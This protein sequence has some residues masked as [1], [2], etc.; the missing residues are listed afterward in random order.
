V[1]KRGRA[2]SPRPQLK[3]GVSGE[4]ENPR[5]GRRQPVRARDRRL[6]EPQLEH[7]VDVAAQFGEYGYNGTLNNPSAY[8]GG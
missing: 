4:L 2:G 1:R 6:Y 5:T 8:V 3:T 7:Q